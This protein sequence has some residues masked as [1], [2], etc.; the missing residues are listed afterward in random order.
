MNTKER[1]VEHLLKSPAIE[2]V[3]SLQKLTAANPE[4]VNSNREDV[5]NI[6]HG[7]LVGG[8]FH[9]DREIF[10]KEWPEILDEALTRL[11]RKKKV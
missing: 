5:G 7:F 3:R 2:Y 11:T 10:E 9:W 4:Y 8:G 1:A 6:I